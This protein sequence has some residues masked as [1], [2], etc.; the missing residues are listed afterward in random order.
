MLAVAQA[1]TLDRYTNNFS[2]FFLFEEFRPSHYPARLSVHSHAFFEVD[3]DEVGADLEVRLL[4]LRG[5]EPV[6]TSN[7]V[8]VKPAGERHRVRISGLA[9]PE[10]G[11]YRVAVE[12]RRSG[13]D[14]AWTREAV[15]WP[16][17]ANTP[18]Q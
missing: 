9:I 18:L 11:Q 15:T 2:L 7:P 10:A 14:G 4:L 8:A 16:L 5:A 17:K 1:S 3:A 6:F 13:S 12:W